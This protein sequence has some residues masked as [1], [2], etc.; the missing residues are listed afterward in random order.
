MHTA[1][2][3]KKM[4]HNIENHEKIKIILVDYSIQL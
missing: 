2:V 1:C 4:T 3:I